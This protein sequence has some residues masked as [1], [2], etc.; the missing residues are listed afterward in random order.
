[1]RR[2]PASVRCRY[3]AVDSAFLSN[4]R[5]PTGAPCFPTREGFQ[6]ASSAPRPGPGAAAA[7]SPRDGGGCASLASAFMRLQSPLDP[8]ADPPIPSL[9]AGRA[10]GARASAAN[11]AVGPWQTGGITLT[12]ST[13]SGWRTCRSSSARSRRCATSTLAIGRNEIVG[14]IGDNG[15]GKSTLIKVMTGVLPPTSGRIFIRDREIDPARLLGAHGA[16]PRDRD[17]LPGPLARRQAAALAQFLRRPADHQPL[18][19][20]R[21]QAGEGDRRRHPA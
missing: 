4:C 10:G 14:L 13:S 17:G 21:H 16:R 20:H 18:R 15:A 19:L 9:K 5:V 3:R 1:M 12:S 2:W 11:M 8:F 7:G 6:R